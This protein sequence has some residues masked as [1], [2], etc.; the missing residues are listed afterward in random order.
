MN[1][2]IVDHR[3]SIIVKGERERSQKSKATRER[4]VCRRKAS[5]LLPRGT[6]ENLGEAQQVQERHKNNRQRTRE[7]KAA[8]ARSST[9]FIGNIF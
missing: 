6:Q 4:G 7:V 8:N 9:S 5:V 1:D 3:S 2:A